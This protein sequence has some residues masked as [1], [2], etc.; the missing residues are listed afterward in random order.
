MGQDS[1]KL[2]FTNT[3]LSG[4]SMYH[5]SAVDTSADRLKIDGAQLCEAKLSDKEWGRC[6]PNYDDAVRRERCKS[7][8]K[9]RPDR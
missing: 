8:R 6:L 2:V 3:N 9:G 4:A 1:T 5:A 7:S